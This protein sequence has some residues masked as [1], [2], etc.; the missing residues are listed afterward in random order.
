MLGALW[1]GAEVPRASSLETST[2]RVA[3]LPAPARS[4]LTGPAASLSPPTA[5]ACKTGLEF[6]LM[7]RT[8]LCTVTALAGR[9]SVELVTLAGLI[10]FLEAQATGAETM[11][12]CKVFALLIRSIT[13]A[14]GVTRC[15][16][17]EGA[18]PRQRGQTAAKG[19]GETMMELDHLQAA[20][21]GAPQ[22]RHSGSA[23]A[24]VPA[25]HGAEA[26]MSGCRASN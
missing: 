18:R 26:C 10:L 11:P 12:G 14:L 13:G 21:D 22:I 15:A 7:L 23:T 25:G 20:P 17:T 24:T 16:G 2:T 8:H 4:S 1:P 6:G 5:C 19:R 9:T 3:S